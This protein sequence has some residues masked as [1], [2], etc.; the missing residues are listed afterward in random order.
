MSD[1]LIDPA[2]LQ[3]PT[4]P[5]LITVW[6]TQNQVRHTSGHQHNRGQ[7]LGTVKGVVRVGTKVGSWLIPPVNAVWLP[8]NVEHDFVSHGAF[9]GW[10]TYIASEAY[11]NLPEA[12]RVIRLSGL[13]TEAVARSA[14]WSE[15]AL[16]PAEE[17]IAR[18]ILDEIVTLP[19]EALG[20]PFPSDVR[21]QRIASEI[22]VNP[23][24]RRR[25]D[26]WA[27]WAGTSP[28][29]LSRRF[30]LETGLTFRAW[31]QRALLLRSL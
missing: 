26:A 18:V 31:R 6:R 24:D 4:E 30:V 15:S 17:N 25:M 13:L 9:H 8:P 20:L 12:P 11:L 14:S 27:S 1:F 21:L 22:L 19:E 28:R 16:S 10:S 23:G 7:L 3:S 2:R 29:T 5:I